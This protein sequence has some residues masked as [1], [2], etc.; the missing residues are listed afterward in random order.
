[1]VQKWLY[2]EASVGTSLDAIRERV[3]AMWCGLACFGRLPVLFIRNVL[4]APGDWLAP[5]WLWFIVLKRA[6]TTGLCGADFRDFAGSRPDPC[7]A[8]P[9]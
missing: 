1:M 3:I 5:V 8:S 9:A 2:P 6:R 7:T 4:N